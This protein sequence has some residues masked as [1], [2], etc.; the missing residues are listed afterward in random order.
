MFP[1]VVW[2]NLRRICSTKDNKGAPLK[3]RGRAFLDGLQFYEREQEKRQ[4]PLFYSWS[5]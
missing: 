4:D 5:Q 2:G 1:S 3:F